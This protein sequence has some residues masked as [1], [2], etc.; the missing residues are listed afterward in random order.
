MFRILEDYPVSPF[1]GL[2][3]KGDLSTS[4]TDAME[5]KKKKSKKKSEETDVDSNR[6]KGVKS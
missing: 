4:C 3:A 5:Q 1:L 6:E 2:L